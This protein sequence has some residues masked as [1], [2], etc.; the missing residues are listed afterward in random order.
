SSL[1]LPARFQE[2]KIQKVCHHLLLERPILHRDRIRIK[3]LQH[4]SH[5]YVLSSK[6]IFISTPA[7]Q[8]T[9]SWQSHHSIVSFSHKDR[10]RYDINHKTTKQNSLFLQ[11]YIKK[12][13]RNN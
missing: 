7:C 3:R 10:H 4:T 9:R 5:I 8:K 12:Y 2:L 1:N 13:G 6:F 11:E